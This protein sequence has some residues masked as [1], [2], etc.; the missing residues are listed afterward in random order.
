MRFYYKGRN[1]SHCGSD[2]TE[3]DNAGD[4]PGSHDINENDE[5][6]DDSL[7][8]ILDNVISTNRPERQRERPM[9]NLLELRNYLAE[10][11]ER[12]DSLRYLK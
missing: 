2:F 6:N 5:S 1:C 12:I 9:H 3:E 4:S 7:H 11:R 8:A 10:I